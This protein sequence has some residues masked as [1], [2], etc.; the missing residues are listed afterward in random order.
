ME[1]LFIEEIK[2]IFAEEF[3]NGKKEI[4]LRS[5]DIHT[6]VGGYPGPK[7]RMPVCCSAM[8]QMM[9]GDDYIQEQP[10]SGNGANL[11]IVYRAKN[12]G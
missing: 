7:H 10:P 4:V 3:G 9:R 2:R 11:Y 12:H 5:G 1:T 6:A 8:R